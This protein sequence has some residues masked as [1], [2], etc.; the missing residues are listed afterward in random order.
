MNS[1][2]TASRTRRVRRLHPR[3]RIHHRKT[4]QEMTPHPKRTPERPIRPRMD[5]RNKAGAPAQRNPCRERLHRSKKLAAGAEADGRDQREGSVKPGSGD[6]GRESVGRMTFL[7][8]TLIFDHCPG[9]RGAHARRISVRRVRRDVEN[10]WDTISTYGTFGQVD[11][12]G[13]CHTT[14]ERHIRL[15]SHDRPV[16]SDPD[17]EPSR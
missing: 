5:P 17:L 4:R 6:R 14:R 7:H 1:C 11:P 13:R 9:S 10:I 15:Q 3:P 16:H 12:E 2:G 8:L